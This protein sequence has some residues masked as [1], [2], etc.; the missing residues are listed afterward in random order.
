MRKLQNGNS[1]LM[2]DALTWCNQ[3]CAKNMVL[4]V[5]C[6]VVPRIFDSLNLKDVFSMVIG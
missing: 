1:G 4:I 2:L 3:I 6:C 5:E